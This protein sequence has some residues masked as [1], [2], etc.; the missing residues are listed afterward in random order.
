MQ[1]NKLNLARL[2]L[3]GKEV[4]YVLSIAPGKPYA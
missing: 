1:E 3:A 4:S 2:V